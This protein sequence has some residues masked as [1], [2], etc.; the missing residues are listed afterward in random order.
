MKVKRVAALQMT[1]TDKVTD[2]LNTIARLVEKA[3]HQGAELVVLPE[4]LAFMG[5][6]EERLKVREPAGSGPIQDFL[7]ALAARLKIW[8]VGGTIPILT[9]DGARAYAR[10]YV[11]DNLGKVAAFY[12]KIHLFDVRVTEQESY[13]ESKTTAAGKKGVALDTSVGKMG[14]SICY[15]LRFPELYRSLVQDGVEI[16]VVPSAFTAITGAA[17]WE[18]LLR[19]RAIENL[20]YVVAAAQTGTHV[21]G[22]KTFGHSMIIDPWGK[23]L[24]VLEAGEG[25]IVADIDLQYLAEVRKRFPALAHRKQQF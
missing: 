22:R 15:D 14:L 4:N 9:E 1:A 12:D 13:E 11:W 24:G 7:A 2:N 17:H 10:C 6:E 5:S 16:F 3:V 21:N 19:A 20:S 23:I 18:S 8:I 25:V